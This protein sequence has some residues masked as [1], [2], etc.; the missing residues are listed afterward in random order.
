VGD[1]NAWLDI[2]GLSCNRQKPR[3]EHGNEKEGWQHIDERHVT[4]HSIKGPGDLFAPGTT[5]AQL[6]RAANKVV[7]KGKRVIENINRRIQ[8]FEKKM[9]I[10]GRKDVV[11]VTVDSHDGNRIITMFPKISGL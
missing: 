11:N 7:V 3:M 6:E 5:R 9:V 1:P 4:G 10:N 2:F 8:T